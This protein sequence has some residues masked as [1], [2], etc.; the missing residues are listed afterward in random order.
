M[1]RVKTLSVWRGRAWPRAE[2]SHFCS[3]RSTIHLQIRSVLSGDSY[4]IRKKNI[5]LSTKM[6]NVNIQIVYIR[7]SFIY[8]I[9]CF[10]H[11]KHI[12]CILNTEE[13]DRNSAFAILFNWSIFLY[14]ISHTLLKSYGSFILQFDT[15]P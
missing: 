4:P 5:F 13:Y 12:F 9:T 10:I 2:K 15:H 6:F 1:E 7:L 3:Q 11:R 8:L 14:I